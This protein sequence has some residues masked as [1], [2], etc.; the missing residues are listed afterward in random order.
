MRRRTVIGGLAAFLA[1]CSRA[2]FAQATGKLPLVG[3]LGMEPGPLLDAFRHGLQELGYVEGQTI[4]LAERSAPDDP[5]RLPALAKE[6]VALK[7][8]VIVV[9]PSSIALVAKQATSVIPIVVTAMADPERLGL[10]ASDARP[11]GNITGIR[12]NLDGLPGKQLE[13]AVEVMSGATRIGFLFNAA[14]PGIAFMPP[15]L[16]AAAAR[17]KVKLV[18]ADVRAP[19]DL[20]AAFQTLAAARVAIV[21]VGQDAMLRGEARRIASL[22][23]AARLPFMDGQREW[24]EAGG[25]I[26]YGVSLR[27]N[28][29]R[30]AYYV[31]RILKG[32]KPDDLPVELPTK[33]EMVVNLKAAKV[34]GIAVPPS[35]LVRADEA[36]E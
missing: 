30:A 19:G 9:Q 12:V 4:V 27:G 11:G 18:R 21:M 23:G 5:E 7:P 29:H 25:V 31:D 20:D 32:A 33:V 24:A 26:S 1:A 17:L 15:E 2:S 35:L 14:N 34:L 6:L 3:L 10:I 22:A 8:D 36:I 28:A 13:I 16:E